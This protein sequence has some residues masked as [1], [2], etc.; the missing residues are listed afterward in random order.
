VT[1]VW[2]LTVK[3]T[4]NQIPIGTLPDTKLISE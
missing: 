4:M 3:Q 2:D 1:N